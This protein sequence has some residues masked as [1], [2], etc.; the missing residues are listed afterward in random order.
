MRDHEQM[1]PPEPQSGLQG[2]GG[3]GH[4]KGREDAIFAFVNLK[5]SYRSISFYFFGY[6]A[7]LLL[8]EGV[9]PF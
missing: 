1:T 4:R 7:S 2:E 8:L 3:P 9:L 5:R 6:N